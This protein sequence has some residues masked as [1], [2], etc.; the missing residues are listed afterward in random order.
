MTRY[1]QNTNVSSEASRNEIE[2][3][4]RKFGATEFAYGWQQGHAAVGFVISGRQVR[5]VLHMPDPN[6]REF[7][8]T[9]TRRTPR[10]PGEA[11]KAYEQ[12]VRQRWRALAA[13][14]KAKLVAVQEGI[15]T[16]EEEFLAHFVLPSGATMAQE[17]IPRLDA[18]L[19]GQSM[20]AL[21]PGRSS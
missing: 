1:A 21:L 9:P 6:D 7:T 2:R 14:I 20:P 13:V 11:E 12:V 18:A 16:I 17:M 8:H 4:L 15:V 5:F 3:T 19:D 10:S